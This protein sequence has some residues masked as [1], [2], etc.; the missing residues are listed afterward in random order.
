MKLS[1]LQY[2]LAIAECK[3]ITKAAEQLYVSQPALSK[4][5]ALL[6]EELGVKLIERQTY[7][8]VLTKVGEEFAKDCRKILKELDKAV[9]KAANSGKKGKEVF[10]ISCFDGAVIDDFMPQ[11]LEFLHKKMPG[12][13]IRLSRDSIWANHKLIEEDAADMIIEPRFSILQG[14]NIKEEFCYKIL[15][16][17]EGALI[18]SKK[19]PLAR[20]K[21]LKIKDFAKEPFFVVNHETEKSLSQAGL[22]TLKQI[23]IL[24]PK[25]EE[26]DNFVSL[27]SN[28]HMGLGYAA[29]AKM[30]ADADPELLAYPLPDEMGMDVVAVWKKENKR[31]SRVM[32]D[33]LS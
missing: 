15:N 7:G 29:L 12:I 4:Q 9:E 26:V 8:I 28:I 23:G 32:R 33:Y 6:E 17:R 19:S 11:L 3:N 20:R 1:Q 13:Q 10:R 16:H 31:A 14:K 25:I 2:F 27:M 30:A 22:D 18:Y 24:N 5:M 21:N